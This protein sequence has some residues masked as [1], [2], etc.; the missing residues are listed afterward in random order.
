MLRF[1]IPNLRFVMAT[2]QDEAFTFEEERLAADAKPPD[3]DD[4]IDFGCDRAPHLQL[5]L[6]AI[7][8][9][10]FGG[11]Q[12]RIGDYH[13]GQQSVIRAT[14]NERNSRRERVSEIAG[15]SD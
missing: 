2:P 9:R 5:Q 11:P 13:L 14:L 4:L 1:E 6:R 12:A 3:A 10:Q 15:R 8:K 7:Q